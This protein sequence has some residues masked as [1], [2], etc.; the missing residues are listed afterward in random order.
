M[1]MPW[2]VGT[3]FSRVRSWIGP[4]LSCTEASCMAKPSMPEKLRPSF[5]ALRSIR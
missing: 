2:S 4:M 1:M 5:C 3:R